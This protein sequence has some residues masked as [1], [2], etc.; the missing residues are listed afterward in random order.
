MILSGGDATLFECDTNN[1]AD[2]HNQEALL[3]FSHVL[4]C[5]PIRAFH[6]ALIQWL[7]YIRDE[8]LV[9]DTCSVKVHPC[10]WMTQ[11]ERPDLRF[12]GTHP[13]FGPQTAPNS[14]LGEKI[15][16]CQV[17]ETDHSE[18]AVE[19][20]HQ[21]MGLETV[22]CTA[23]DHDRQMATQAI[24]HF[25]GRASAKSG[26]ER[27]RLSTKTHEHFMKIQDIVCGNS[28]ELFHDM[29]RFNPF[30]AAQREAFLEAAHSIH[31]ELAPEN[32]D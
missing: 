13:L 10:Q 30:A 4:F 23:E 7:P 12:I 17:G 11:Q 29:N 21:F 18:E 28:E 5:V 25:I 31:R 32:P 24:N 19:F 9:A 22:V 1:P 26:L 27:V 16:I 8:S 14:C 15:A 2:T 20:F 3:C 6:N